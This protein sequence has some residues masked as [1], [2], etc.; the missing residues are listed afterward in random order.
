M[1]AACPVSHAGE[2][3]ESLRTR[4]GATLHLASQK[5]DFAAA[6]GPSSRHLGL[7]GRLFSEQSAVLCPN[8][9]AHRL[10]M[11]NLSSLFR[12]TTSS[13]SRVRWMSSS[14]KDSTKSSTECTPQVW[15]PHEACRQKLTRDA[16]LP[17]L[18]TERWTCLLCRAA[19]IAQQ[20]LQRRLTCGCCIK[21][22]YGPVIGA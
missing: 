13:S 16:A 5:A 15:D 10:S 18:V 2:L 17:W 8:L 21:N 11:Q 3:S 4:N 14:S 12:W 6:T 22:R 1:L 9:S 19:A 20:L 7:P